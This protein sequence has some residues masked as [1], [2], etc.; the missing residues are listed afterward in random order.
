M[1]V[2]VYYEY[3]MYVEGKRYTQSTQCGRYRTSVPRLHAHKQA[4][5]CSC[6]VCTSFMSVP[7]SCH[8]P[9]LSCQA[10]SPAAAPWRSSPHCRTRR[11]SPP[12]SDS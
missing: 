10:G 7:L 9:E 3:Y 11:A 4:I 1:D 8:G 6:T 2:L 12:P 5:A